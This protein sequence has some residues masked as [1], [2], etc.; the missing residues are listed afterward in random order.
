MWIVAKYKKKDFNNLTNDIQKVFG[1]ESIVYRPKILIEKFKNNKLIETEL[2]LIND[3]IF[4]FNQSFNK[5][6]SLM[7]LSYAKGIKYILNNSPFNQKDLEEF[8]SNCKNFESKNGYITQDFFNF[9]EFKKFKFA[10]GPF[11]NFIFE[12]INQ[13]KN[14]IKILI[15]KKTFIINK[16]KYLYFPI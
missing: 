1:R 16:N 7:K 8:V 9:F 5:E 3:Y 14:K 4:I 11:A 15:G 12:C 13:T 6:Y 2:D 10:S